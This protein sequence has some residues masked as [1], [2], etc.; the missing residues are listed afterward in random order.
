MDAINQAQSIATSGA[1][2]IWACFLNF[3]VLLVIAA[4][5]FAFSYKFGRASFLSLIIAFYVGFAIYTVFPYTAVITAAGT[6]PLSTTVA[7]VLLYLVLTG[8]SYMVIRKSSD[9]G[10]LTMGNI[11]VLIL[12]LLTGGFLIALSYHTFAIQD[13]YRFTPQI[14]MYFTPA[15]YFFWWFIAPILGLIGLAR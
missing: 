2:E 9:G 4:V 3:M 10:I 8:V 12:A 6:T 11:G 1:L 14:E 15:K 5:L 7:S 13:L